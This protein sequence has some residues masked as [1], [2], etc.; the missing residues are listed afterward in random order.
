MGWLAR[1]IDAGGEFRNPLEQIE[2]GLFLTSGERRAKTS[3]F[4]VLLVPLSLA[5]LRTLHYER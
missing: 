2:D 5:S 4:W 1:A 3:Q